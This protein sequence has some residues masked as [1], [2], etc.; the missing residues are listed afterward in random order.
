MNFEVHIAGK[1]VF[2]VFTII[3]NR[4]ET[5]GYTSCVLQEWMY[6]VVDR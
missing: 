1:P 6:Q 5:Q 4:F 2:L 3:S